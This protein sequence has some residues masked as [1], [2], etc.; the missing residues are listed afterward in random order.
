MNQKIEHTLQARGQANTNTMLRHKG[1][2]VLRVMHGP[3][4]I[5]R[6]HG[7]PTLGSPSRLTLRT[8]RRVANVLMLCALS[9]ATSG[10]SFVMAITTANMVT[11]TVMKLRATQAAGASSAKQKQYYLSANVKPAHI[12]IKW[13]VCVPR[14]SGLHQFEYLHKLGFTCP[15]P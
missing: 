15:E 3:N 11:N 8:P 4:P 5:M 10:R 6:V 2:D 13:Q 7:D 14:A 12:E 1:A 9:P